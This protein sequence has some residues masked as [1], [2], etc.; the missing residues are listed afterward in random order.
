MAWYYGTFSCGCEGRVNITGP[1]KNRQWIADRKFEGLC[2][3]CY[4]IKVEQDKIR[5]NEEAE[6]K[7][8][9]MELP[10]LTGTE[11]QVIWAN[12]I[13]V[14]LIENITKE[15]DKRRKLKFN[16]ADEFV[17]ALHYLIESRT[18]ASF[19][20]DNR[21]N[22]TISKLTDIYKEKQKKEEKAI[23]EYK[24]NEIISETAISPGEVK[25]NGI[26]N[27]NVTEDK[28]DAY[29][30]KNE[31]FRGVVKAL[32]YK[33]NNGCWSRKISETN[34]NYQDRAAELANKL[35]NSGF[36]VS[37]QDEIIREK[38][39][40]GDYE[41]ECN[42]WI[43]RREDTN[44]LAINWEGKNDALY[45][46][47]KKL[48]GARWS[49]PSML[50]D[51]SHYIEVEEF[52]EMYGFK[53]TKKATDLIGKY[54]EELNNIEKIN[55]TKVEEATEKNGLED[56]LNSSREVLDDLREDD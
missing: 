16:D 25:H 35:L 34:G 17:L 20:I 21:Y 38:A 36:T 51:V 52:A 43:K 48:P 56:I 5:A 13:R 2:E 33:W 26:V 45:S 53:F 49:S 41:Q 29:Y 32:N 23:E 7:A 22:F 19:W 8:K 9:E 37:I 50:V 28:I 10:E 27:I 44:K 24:I 3:D 30:E 1:T 14:E 6:V 54:I 4:K 39:V 15:I 18:K 42:R 55:V 11:K 46:T 47:S 12:T 40:N 31:C